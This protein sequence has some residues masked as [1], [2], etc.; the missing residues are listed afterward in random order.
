MKDF[1]KEIFIYHHHFNQL[2]V[3]EVRIHKHALTEDTYKMFCHLLNAHQVWNSRVL[4]EPSLK[5]W[6]LHEPEEL[7]ALDTKNYEDTLRILDKTDLDAVISYTNSRGEAYTN[8]VK[9]ILFHI[10]TI[11]PITRASLPQLFV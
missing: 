11:L 4:S 2:L 8:A 3:E 10:T 6:E 5:V 9:D 1:F 7:K